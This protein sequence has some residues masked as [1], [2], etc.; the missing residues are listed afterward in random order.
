MAKKKSNSKKVKRKKKVNTMA[1]TRKRRKKRTTTIRRAAPIQ[2]RRRRKKKGLMDGNSGIWMS[3]KKNG[4]GALG[5]GLLLLTRFFAM[6]L[7]ARTGI[8]YAGGIGISMA[9]A[10]F[11]GAGLSGATTFNLGQNLFGNFLNDDLEDTE[12]VDPDTLSD[13]GMVDDNGDPIVMDDDNVMYALN[14]GGELQ[15][16]GDANNLQNVS[17]VPLQD[18]YSLNAGPYDL[19]SY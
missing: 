8:G 14:D 13:T 2:R 11:V 10:P 7:W 15:A 3:L 17:M 6:P 19:S 5:G 4:A 9:G 16:I 18:A 12:Y 1:T